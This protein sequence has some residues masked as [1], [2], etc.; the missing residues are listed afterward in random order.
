M[1]FLFEVRVGIEYC[2]IPP[3]MSPRGALEHDIQLKEYIL[4][5]INKILS[6]P[7]YFDME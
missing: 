1:I 6:K 4:I 7:R 3:F 5:I 2:S